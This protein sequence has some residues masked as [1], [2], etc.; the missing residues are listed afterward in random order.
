MIWKQLFAKKSLEQLHAEAMGE[1]RLR[2]VLGP[3][4]LT[5]LGIGAIIGAGI[6]VM[7]GRVAA[8]DAGPAVVTSYIVA[9][10]ACALA[11]FCYAEFAAMAPVAGSAYTYA[12]ASLGE[13]FAWIIG[14]DLILEYAMSAATVA[15]VWSK[16]LNELLRVCFGEGAV[17]PERWCGPPFDLQG[18]HW[19]LT[20]NIMNLPAVVILAVVTT[21]LVI[22]IR[23]SAAS[24]TALVVLKL[25]VVLFVIAVGAFY[26]DPANWTTIPPEERRQPEELLI[27][28]LAQERH[29]ENPEAAKQLT[30]QAV[31]TFKMQR[32]EASD[33]P[34]RIERVKTHFGDVLAKITPA[35]KQQIADVI[36]EAEE[37]APKKAAQQ[38]ARKWGM[39]GLIGLNRSLVAV[40]NNVRSPYFPF[41]LSGM[42]LGAALVFFAFIG[43][44]S[45]STHAEEAVRPQRDVPIGILASLFLC[46]LLYVLV[47][48][49]ITGMVPYPYIDPDAAVASAF[50]QRAAQEG[51]SG[52]LHAAAGLIA[53]GALAGMT[54]VL[55]ITFLSQARV[56]LAMAR[57]NLLPHNIF[58]VVHPR[59]RTPHVSTMLTGG[60]MCVVAAF[61]PIYVL[62]EMVNIGTLFAFVVVCAAVFILRIQRPDAARPF[63]C[64][65]VFVVAPLGIL[66]N[67]ILMLF[68]PVDT[69]LRLVIWMGA[70]L[71]IYFCFGLRYSALGQQMRKQEDATAAS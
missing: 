22:G 53:A 30:V 63:R 49:I 40:D 11:A 61:T 57:D 44:D 31:A 28:K 70:G 47:A 36:K 27:P 51:G 56:F 32:A 16:Y 55:L 9:G 69:W 10:I 2:R 1:N 13:V 5:S 64:P 26:I 24:N 7:T 65:G 37:E 67:L 41:G 45:I 3:V 71:V 66:V 60:L 39:F 12:Y 33:D 8:E 52:L 29:K 46:T 18:D 50:R 19:V 42:M 43:F 38:E 6:F 59:F 14:W 23:E 15:A 62:E 4:A 21:I 20:G 54:S 58:G 68:L 17:V 34:D 25:G 48:G 35:D